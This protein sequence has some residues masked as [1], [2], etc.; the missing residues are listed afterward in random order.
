MSGHGHACPRCG[1]KGKTRIRTGNG[2]QTVPCPT[3]GGSGLL[4]PTGRG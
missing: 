3:C 2:G 4:R 1:G